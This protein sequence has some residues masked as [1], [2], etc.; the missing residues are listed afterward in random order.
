[1]EK[2]NSQLVEALGRLKLTMLTAGYS[3]SSITAYLREISYISAYYRMGVALCTAKHS[4][5]R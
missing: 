1:M 5:M 2:L 3:R 4:R